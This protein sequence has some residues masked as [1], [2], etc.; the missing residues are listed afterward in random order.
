MPKLTGYSKSS[1]KSKGASDKFLYEE[2]RKIWNKSNSVPQGTRKKKNK[3]RH[4][5]H[6]EG[7]KEDQSRN[8]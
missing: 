4:S 5:Q 2:A 8:I 6:K 7:N 3:L 1:S